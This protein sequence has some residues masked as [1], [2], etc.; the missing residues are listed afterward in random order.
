MGDRA[1]VY[2]RNG[3]AGIGVYGHWAGSSIASAAAKVLASKAFKAR[4]GDPNYATRI[5]VQIVLEELGAEPSSETGFG[6]WTS[7]GGADDNEYPYIVIDVN[8]GKVFVAADWKKPKP[9]ER[10]EKPT[11]KKLLSLMTAGEEPDD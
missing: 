5:G 6:L 11:E 2:F 9:S 1:N 4:I 10:V 7:V 3:K 8:D